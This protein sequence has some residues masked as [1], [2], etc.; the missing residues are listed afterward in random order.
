MFSFLHLLFTNNNIL[1]FFGAVYV[2]TIVEVK[3]RWMQSVSGWLTAFIILHKFYF[4]DWDLNTL[5]FKYPHTFLTRRE[6]RF[7]STAASTV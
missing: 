1:N 6:L 5:I 4:C 7:T 3:Q 2:S